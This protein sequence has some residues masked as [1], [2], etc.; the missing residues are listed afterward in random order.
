M[1]LKVED[2]SSKKDAAAQGNRAHGVQRQS[3]R[4]KAWHERAGSQVKARDHGQ[5]QQ[6]ALCGREVFP[7]RRNGGARFLGV[8]ASAGGNVAGGGEADFS[9]PAGFDDVGSPRSPE[10]SAVHGS[11]A[12]LPCEST[13]GSLL[14]MPGV[15]SNSISGTLCGGDVCEPK[16]GAEF[17]PKFGAK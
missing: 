5:H 2:L 17:G 14:A 4:A 8:V 11:G 7:V 10:T 12:S 1:F 13:A 9:L 6:K 3:K 15:A 16:F